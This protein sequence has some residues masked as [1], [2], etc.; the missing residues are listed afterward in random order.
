MQIPL[1]GLQMSHPIMA[2]NRP[3]IVT[4]EV[5]VVYDGIL[6]RYN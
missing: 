2:L 4:L 1:R 6:N 5:C 3:N